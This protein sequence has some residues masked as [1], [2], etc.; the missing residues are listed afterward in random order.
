MAFATAMADTGASSQYA[1][2]QG[3]WAMN[4]VLGLDL[5]FS[6]TTAQWWRNRYAEGYRVM[7]QCLWT[8]GLAGFDGIKAVA[9]RNLRYA[10]EASFERSGYL[11]A[12]PPDWWADSV[13]ISRARECA[14]AEW[15]GVKV[16]P[17]DWEIEGTPLWRCDALAGALVAAGKNA[18]ILYTRA[19]IIGP[20]D[21]RSFKGLWLAQFDENPDLASTYL[22]YRESGQN[23]PIGPHG[24]VAGKQWRNTHTVEG[25]SI[26]ADT[27]DIDFWGGTDDVTTQA[28]W[29]QI[30]AADNSI[31]S[32]VNQ[33]TT[34]VVNVIGTLD[35]RLKALEGSPGADDSAEIAAIRATL[36]QIAKA[37]SG[38][39]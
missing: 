3:W 29:E 8:G 23:K 25:V 13:A 6:A 11:N 24:I 7:S 18:D 16:M 10:R 12:G 27:F 33:L 32:L 31:L 2:R 30:A 9:E 26:D 34:D 14:G 36:T 38:D 21:T 1:C 37:A 4:H 17:V 39:G 28:D 19:G 22:T 15:D 5:S 20:T 35:A